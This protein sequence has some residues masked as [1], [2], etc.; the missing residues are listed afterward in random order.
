MLLNFISA[1]KLIKYCEFVIKLKHNGLSNFS[2]EIPEDQHTYVSFGKISLT[3]TIV[4]DILIQIKSIDEA[5]IFGLTHDG[6]IY[7]KQSIDAEIKNFYEFMVI[8]WYFYAK[9]LLRHW[10]L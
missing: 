7:I 5:K 8:Y 10:K 1:N 2:F 3:E 6:E 4:P 9:I